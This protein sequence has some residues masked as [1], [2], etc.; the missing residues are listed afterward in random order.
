[1]FDSG[2]GKGKD[3]SELSRRRFLSGVMKTA[4][5]VG[6]MGVGIGLYSE[7]A[8]SLPALA[9]RPPGAIPEDEFLNACIPFSIDG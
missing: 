9:I 8:S 7:Q 3:K 6:L 4:C 2:N 5:G 1:M